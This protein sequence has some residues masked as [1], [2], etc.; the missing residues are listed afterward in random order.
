MMAVKQKNVLFHVKFVVQRRFVLLFY[1]RT[2]HAFM[3]VIRYL[4]INYLSHVIR[5]Q[6]IFLRI[7]KAASSIWKRSYLP[8]GMKLTTHPQL[9]P[10][11]RMRGAVPPLPIHLHDLVLRQSTGC[12]FMAW[13]LVKFRDNFTLFSCTE[14]ILN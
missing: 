5:L 2:M 3:A 14:G 12:V 13:Y 10:R 7:F 4:K 8:R 6:V 9:V 11:L 1:G